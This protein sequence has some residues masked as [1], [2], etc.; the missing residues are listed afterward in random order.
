MLKLSTKEL[1]LCFVVIIIFIIVKIF[2]LHLPST[3]KLINYTATTV[4]TATSTEPSTSTDDKK[5]VVPSMKPEE[6]KPTQTEVNVGS[7]VNGESAIISS[8][9]TCLTVIASVLI[10]SLLMA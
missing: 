2:T 4:V 9:V 1:I 3:I 6:N 7:L 8:S 10:L 5:Q